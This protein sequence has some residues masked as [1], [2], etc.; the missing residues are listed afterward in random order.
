M[1]LGVR[2]NVP[3][4][5]RSHFSC[6]CPADGLYQTGGGSW[7]VVLIAPLAIPAI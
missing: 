4:F 1:F 7:V 2:L 3:L 5:G 6:L